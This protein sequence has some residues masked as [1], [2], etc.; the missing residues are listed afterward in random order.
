MT[1]TLELIQCTETDDLR[2]N[3][4]FQG[5][6]LA[7]G[8]QLHPFTEEE[9]VRRLEL[10]SEGKE[11][12]A[13]PLIEMGHKLEVEVDDHL[14][15][16]LKARVQYELTFPYW[17]VTL[18]SDMK[19]GFILSEYWRLSYNPF[20]G[21]I[22]GWGGISVQGP[23]DLKP[24]Q[25]GEVKIGFYDASRYGLVEQNRKSMIIIYEPRSPTGF[26][27]T[28]DIRHSPTMWV[29]NEPVTPQI[30]D[31]CLCFFGLN[32]SDYY[33]ANEAL[34]RYNLKLDRTCGGTAYAVIPDE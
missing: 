11:N 13:W 10:I 3:I 14:L 12:C 28:N 17:E 6:R 7:C 1:T 2:W 9:A 30:G 16:A 15:E 31:R 33:D 24:N 25:W 21:R 4:E 20:T 22:I 34:K 19:S 27:E 8:E 29:G 5:H 18:R 26:V 23:T 32:G